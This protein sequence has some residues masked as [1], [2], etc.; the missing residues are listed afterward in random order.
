VHRIREA[1]DRH[2]GPG[3]GWALVPDCKIVLL[4]R[5]PSLDAADEIVLDGEPLAMMR[6]DPGKGWNLLLRMEGARRVAPFVSKSFLIIDGG[7]VASISKGASPMAVGVLECDEAIEPGDETVVLTEDRRALSVGAARMRG[8]EMVGGRGPA[9]KNRCSEEPREARPCPPGQSWHDAVRASERSLSSRRS[10]ARGFIQELA[11]GDKPLAVS[12]S[13][14]KDSLAVLL[15]ALEAGLKPPMIFVDTGIEL[16]E[17]IKH[18]H[19]TA[20][21]F[22]LELV[23]ERAPDS[24]WKGMAHFGP[25]A[26]DFRWCCKTCKLGPTS[27][28]I[29]RRFPKGVLSL[30]GQRRYESE[31]R[32]KKGSVWMNPWVPGQDAASPIQEWTA[33]HVW[34]YIFQ[35]KAPYNPWYARGMPRIGCWVCPSADLADVETMRENF[36]GYERYTERLRAFAAENGFPEEWVTLALWRWK[37]FAPK[38]I[39]AVAGKPIVRRQRARPLNAQTN[40]ETIRVDELLFIVDGNRESINGRKLAAK[41]L[42]C[43]ACGICVARCPE[44]ALE[45]R[46]GKV[47]LDAAKC[48]KC[49]ICL[50]PCPVADFDPR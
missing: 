12:F 13:G 46:E 39:E 9:S 35:Q 31:Q 8:R 30:I 37:D 3:C 14:G 27:R 24:F 50:S 7:A 38:D 40:E 10:R 15:L 44:G 16:P 48:K 25:P 29:R 45:L 1:A 42:D 49:L 32:S 47:R 43:Q 22:G 4:N 17:T 21:H 6:Y 41:A 33:L 36:P 34:L 18:V 20:S 28:I 2:F 11:S 23:E 26:K 19:E 5:V